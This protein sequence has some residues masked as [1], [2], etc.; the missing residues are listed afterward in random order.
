MA[1]AAHHSP[2]ASPTDVSSASPG[3]SPSTAPSSAPSPQASPV[4][5]VSAYG[6]LITMGNSDTYTISLI[7]VDGKVAASAVASRPAQI[8]CGG[9]AGA[10]LPLPLSTSDTRAYFLDAQGN[11]NFLAPNGETGH[12]TRVPSGGQTR[13]MFAVSPD[14]RR[15][16][17]V[18]D[19]F[20]ASGATTV[21]YVED[22]NG[23][24][25]HVQIFSETGGS[26]LWPLGWH[27]ATNLVLAK[28]PSCTQ[29]GGPFSYGP[30]EL[31][32]VDPATA[33]RRVTIG[34]PDCIIASAP[35]PAGALCESAAIDF[36]VYDWGGQ[37]IKQEP[38][39]LTTQVPVYLSPNGQHVAVT[40]GTTTH[41]QYE[42]GSLAMSVCGWI[43]DTHILDGGD[44]QHQPRVGTIGS[45]SI[46]PVAAQGVCAGRIPGGL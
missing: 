46:V 31:H 21:L 13:S 17:V 34:G 24:T 3:A 18:E 37:L 26:S 12:A 45:G 42:Q 5:V 20:T 4:P 14:D 28:V 1:T 10:V 7:G 6:V 15:I 33:V 29:G 25:N 9:L 27:G 43:D 2:V 44:T 32:V 16:A 40:D 8:T 19:T 23:A 36:K 22:L 39:G 30:Q 41:L 38:S 35:T 11:V